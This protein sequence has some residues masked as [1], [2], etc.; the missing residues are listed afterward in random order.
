VTAD[1]LV[2]DAWQ[3]ALHA[4]AADGW[5]QAWRAAD[6]LVR[7]KTGLTIRIEMGRVAKADVDDL[8]ASAELDAAERAALLAL[9]DAVVAGSADPWG[10]AIGAA[11]ASIGGAT[12]SAVVDG[13]RAS[14][15]DALWG[16]AM[17]AAAEAL[18]AVVADGADVAAR[19]VAAAL[20]READGAAS[21]SLA[22]YAL[23]PVAAALVEAAFT[24]LDTHLPTGS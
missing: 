11:R 10:D 19:A 12:W 8:R 3:A 5:E 20:A 2:E 9:V 23:A 1:Q 21:R 14:V 17:A 7:E 22:P 18:A 6:Q 16:E 24:F 13:S 4:V 15:G